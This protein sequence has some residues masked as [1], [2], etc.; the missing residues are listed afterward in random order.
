VSLDTKILLNSCFVLTFEQD[1]DP[2]VKKTAENE[3]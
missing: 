3:R 2:L 1:K